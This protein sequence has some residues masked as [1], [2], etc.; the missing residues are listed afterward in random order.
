MVVLLAAPPDLGRASDYSHA[1]IETLIGD[2]TRLKAETPGIDSR[3]VFFS[4]FAKD[5]APQ[6]GAGLLPVE[7]PQVPEQMRELVRRGVD[8]LP[9]L[10]AHLDDK[11]PTGISIQQVSPLPGFGGNLF[12]DEYDPRDRSSAG[13]P[14]M[15]DFKCE[16]FVDTY[17]IKV[18]DVCEVLIGQIVNRNLFAVRYQPT[19]ILIVNSPVVAPSLA[20]RIRKDWGGLDAKAH[21]AS[22]LSDLHSADDADGWAGYANALLRLQYYYP[23]TYAALS[24]KDLEKRNAFEAE[25]RREKSRAEKA[26]K[27]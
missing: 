7:E 27:K 12:W 3:G 6:F 16:G 21:E 10:L 1:P 26:K 20:K 15:A 14:C 17:T 9:S 22:L 2:L 18:G 25:E 5:D 24:G 11:R 8:A 19:L 13:E 4:F 23:Q